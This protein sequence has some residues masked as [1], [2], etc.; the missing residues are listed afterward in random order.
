VEPI[1]VKDEAE[2]VE[3]TTECKVD[4]LKLQSDLTEMEVPGGV[5]FTFNNTV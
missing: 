1:V 4:T 3:V 2:V 5:V